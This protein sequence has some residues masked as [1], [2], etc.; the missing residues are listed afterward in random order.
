[1]TLMVSGGDKTSALARDTVFAALMITCNGIVGLSSW[2]ALRGI[3]SSA[4][5]PKAPAPHWPR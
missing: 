4:S 3:A 5:T 1:M 2:S